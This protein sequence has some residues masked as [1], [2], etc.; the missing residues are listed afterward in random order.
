MMSEQQK[1]QQFQET[2]VLHASY[3]SKSYQCRLPI[4][5]LAAPERICGTALR[6]GYTVE[7]NRQQAIYRLKLKGAG[8][9]TATLPAFFIL[10]KGV[11]VLYKSSGAAP[12]PNDA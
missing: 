4:A 12:Q 2:Y 3:I 6:V 7:R 10:D 11:F 1:T 5:A 8:R 9:K